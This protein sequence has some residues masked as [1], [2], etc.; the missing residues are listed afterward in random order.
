LKRALR[1]V[2]GIL[3][4]GALV[5]ATVLGVSALD[6]ALTARMDTLRGQGIAAVERLM[7][8]RVT[9]GSI[10]PSI[11]RQI[12]IRDLAVR[13][14][15]GREIALVRTLRVRYSLLGL[16]TSRDPV[17]SLREIRIVGAEIHLDQEADR[18]LFDLAAR[19]STPG[20]QGMPRLRLTG[21][22]VDAEVALRGGHFSATGLSFDAGGS[23]D[24]GVPWRATSPPRMP[25][26]ASSRSTR[27][28]PRPG[29]RPCRSRGP[30]AGWR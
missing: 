21:T 26:C 6:R 24:R 30:G 25:P 7:G 9:Y 2:L 23:G 3:T 10:S 18:D 15:D 1:F 17:A 8:R 4:F 22:G 14:D 27:S 20:S 28:S 11:L 16:L 19:L 29:R 5:V 12:V 13:A